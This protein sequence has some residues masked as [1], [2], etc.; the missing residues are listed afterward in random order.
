MIGAEDFDLNAPV[1]CARFCSIPSIE[2]LLF[3]ES[4]RADLVKGNF[5]LNREI[6]DHGISASLAQYEI[7]CRGSYI[8]RMTLD[9]YKVAL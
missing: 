2:R 6:L 8:V 5:A 9:R 1:L 3:A 7:V 4:N